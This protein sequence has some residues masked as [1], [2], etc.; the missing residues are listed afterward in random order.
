MRILFLC[1]AN[2]ARSQMAEGLARAIL[3][4][5]VEIESAGSAP[6]IVNP[7]AVETMAEAGMTFPGIG[8]DGLARPGETFM[9]GPRHPG[10]TGSGRSRAAAARARVAA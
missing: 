4:A 6:S 7:R 8:R 9:P 3:P 1:V 2:S 10:R 5:S